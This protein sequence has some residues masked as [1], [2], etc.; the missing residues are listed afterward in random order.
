MREG[1]GVQGYTEEEIV[2]FLLECK[3]NPQILVDMKK[4]ALRFSKPDAAADIARI[5]VGDVS[6]PS[7][8]Q[9]AGTL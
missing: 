3:G 6:V 7:R 4:N 5:V 8:A 2:R 1:I 9:R